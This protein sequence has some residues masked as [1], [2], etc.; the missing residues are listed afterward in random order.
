MADGLYCFVV[1]VQRSTVRKGTKF[2]VVIFFS[3]FG[4]HCHYLFLFLFMLL[5]VLSKNR[6]LFVGKGFLSVT[7]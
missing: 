7:R 2:G 6:F 5:L 1:M 3:L 4:I